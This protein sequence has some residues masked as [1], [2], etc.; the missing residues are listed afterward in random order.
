M[1]SC[2]HEIFRIRKS[3]LPVSGVAFTNS[4]KHGGIGVKGGFKIVMAMVWESVEDKDGNI[5]ATGNQE[6]EGV[7][8]IVETALLFR[9]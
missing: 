6:I 5:K 3:F 4:T 9:N 8:H 7:I 2:Y 1:K